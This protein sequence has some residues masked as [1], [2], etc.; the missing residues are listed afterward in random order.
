MACS[1]L[2]Q[3]TRNPWKATISCAWVG[4]GDES[5]CRDKVDMHG[6]SLEKAPAFLVGI[7]LPMFQALTYNA[8]RVTIVSCFPYS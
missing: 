3:T 5:I 1:K 7:G 8:P 6:C 2:M 4:S